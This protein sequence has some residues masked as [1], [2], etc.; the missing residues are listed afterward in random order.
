MNTKSFITQCKLGLEGQ[1]SK[2]LTDLRD[3]CYIHQIG[4]IPN[5]K[6]ALRIA[7]ITDP[8]PNEYTL[9]MR[10]ERRKEEV[11][12]R[13]IADVDM[14]KVIKENSI[15]WIRSKKGKLVEEDSFQQS[16]D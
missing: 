14:H 4:L 16:A 15:I 1:P 10:D 5:L 12:L 8:D 3:F 7:L 6:V 11:N 9:Y 13:R 2:P